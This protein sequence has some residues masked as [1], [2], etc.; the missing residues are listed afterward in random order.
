MNEL[1]GF[2][3]LH[4]SV[5]ECCGSLSIEVLNKSGAAGSVRVITVDG[6]AKAGEDF[7]AVDEVLTFQSGQKSAFVSVR[8]FDDDTWDPDADFFC[9]LY[10]W[11]SNEELTGQDTK[12]RVTII[13]DDQPGHIGFDYEKD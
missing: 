5:S 4:Y 7:E 12:T 10:S 11:P 1:F 3:C 2:N 13:D 8:I 9:Q 6:D